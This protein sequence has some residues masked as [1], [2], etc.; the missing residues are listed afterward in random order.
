VR[1]RLVVS[2]IVAGVLATAG[3]PVAFASSAASNDRSSNWAGYAIHRAGISFTEV[4]GYWR[5]PRAACTPGHRTYS[6]YWVGL[7]GYALHS[8]ALEQIGTE[9]DCTAS[10]RLQSSAWYELVPA[11]SKTIRFAVHP[12]DIL[13]ASVTV[14]GHQ[15]QFV[16]QDGTTGKTYRKALP[17]PDVDL[18]SAEWI[19]EAPSD[20]VSA[21]ACQTLPL[22]NFGSAAFGLTFAKTASGQIGS[23]SDPEWRYSKISLVPHGHRFVKNHGT[24]IS[25][26]EALP[27]ALGAGGDGF[28]VAFSVAYSTLSLRSNPVTAARD[29]VR[30]YEPLIRFVR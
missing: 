3:A 13:S 23:I 4:A 5:Q 16:L 12:G 27:G 28:S 6:A 17:A 30:S 14:T 15:A 2:M 20:C 10:G 1:N 24:A 26:G 19:V 8:T 18:S 21:N 9:L 22:A 25:V 29:D 7:G 11:P